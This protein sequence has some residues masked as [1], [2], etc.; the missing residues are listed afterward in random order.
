MNGE[1]LARLAEIPGAHITVET[2]NGPVEMTPLRYLLDPRTDYGNLTT[3]AKALFPQAYAASQEAVVAISTTEPGSPEY[4]AA[5]IDLERMSHVYGNGNYPKDTSQDQK[6]FMKNG[7]LMAKISARTGTPVP[8]VFQHKANLS[9]DILAREAENA[10]KPDTAN[11]ARD[12]A[13]EARYGTSYVEDYNNTED[14][15]AQRR[16]LWWEQTQLKAIKANP[17]LAFSTTNGTFDP[18]LF[19]YNDAPAPVDAKQTYNSPGRPQTVVGDVIQ[20]LLDT[21]EWTGNGSSPGDYLFLQVKQATGDLFTREEF[22]KALEDLTDPTS[23]GGFR[24]PGHVAIATFINENFSIGDT[25]TAPTLSA[26]ER[27]EAISNV[28]YDV[29]IKP[30]SELSG[31]VMTNVNIKREVSATGEPL[32]GRLTAREASEAHL[33]SAEEASIDKN[34]SRVIISGAAAGVDATLGSNVATSVAGAAKPIL[35]KGVTAG[36]GAA[37]KA[38][39]EAK[40][41]AREIV[42]TISFFSWSNIT[43]KAGLWGA[44]LYKYWNK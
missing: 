38:E 39:A 28:S 33:S 24:D 37:L 19:V 8:E 22:D 11:E 40:Q 15:D 31:L 35:T 1:Q 3:G 26:N 9:S 13:Y 17:H 4:N 18:S 30:G 32:T 36:I 5:M 7:F 14:P 41:S 34:V 16:A 23:N 43:K 12:M 2:E 20:T 29:R 27:N 21:P 6:D 44:D 10:L 25:N 42:D